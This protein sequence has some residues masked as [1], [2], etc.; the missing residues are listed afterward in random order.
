MYPLL[1]CDSRC[2][3]AIS[4]V[5]ARIYIIKIA[6]HHINIAKPEV[7]HAA[8]PPRFATTVEEEM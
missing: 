1:T 8:A 2:R 5:I 6:I 7:A 4:N 3:P